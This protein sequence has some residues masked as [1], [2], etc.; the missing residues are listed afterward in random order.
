[1]GAISTSV[2]ADGD[3]D[4]AKDVSQTVFVDLAKAARTLPENVM[5]DGWLHRHTC[6]VAATLMRGERRRQARERQAVEMSALQDHSDSD[7]AQISPVLDQAINELGTED[8][9]AI[10]LP[11]SAG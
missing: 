8:R 9:T 7:L 6:F 3:A 2:S 5:L 11:A 10:M 1:L 4:L